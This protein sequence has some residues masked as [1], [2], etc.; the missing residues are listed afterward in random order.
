MGASSQS[1][2]R[3]ACCPA[4]LRVL[5]RAAAHRDFCLCFVELPVLPRRLTELEM[6]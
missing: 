3:S 2:R 4:G 1:T 6:A 5:S